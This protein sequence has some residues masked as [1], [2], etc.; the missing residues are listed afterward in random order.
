MRRSPTHWVLFDAQGMGRIDVRMVLQTD[1]GVNI[2]VQYL[3]VLELNA[4][5]QSALAEGT[6]TRFGDN[7]FMTQPRFETG[8]TRYAWLNDV[9]AVA[10]GRAIA[11]GVEYQIYACEAG[12]TS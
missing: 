2:Y 3:G 8:D 9:V 12:A 1:D 5:M 6:E 10:E 7:Y 4:A 11:G